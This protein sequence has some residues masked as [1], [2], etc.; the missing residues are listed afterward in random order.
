VS[1]ASGIA[2]R[3]TLVTAD[4]LTGAARISGHLVA[5][6]GARK[7]LA[8]LRAELASAASLLAAIE[9]EASALDAASP[10]PLSIE[11]VI[12]ASGPTR[13]QVAPQS[14]APAAHVR[15]VVERVEAGRITRV[16]ALVAVRPD[17]LEAAGVLSLAADATT[18]LA[19]G[20]AASAGA[21]VGPLA[22][23]ASEVRVGSIWVVADLAAEDAP[24]L[25]MAA[26]VVATAGGLTSDAAI[27]A[28][29]LRK[30]CAVS[31]PIR[32]EDHGAGDIVSLDGGT[33]E[34][35]RG[36]LAVRWS[37]AHP[38]AETLLAWAVEVAGDEGRPGEILARAQA[39]QGL[40][41]P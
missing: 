40:P 19:R 2:G 34:V 18:L 25:T 35:H 1:D 29:A 16:E 13:V 33:G 27:M 39:G 11:W 36:A 8:R 4:P 14:L 28:R 5:P 3:L 30:P 9:A 15:A 38:H 6:S 41:R 21:A 23:A 10:H 22:M 26:G 17:Q 7:D 24:L 12:D 20:L 31:T 32:S 37:A